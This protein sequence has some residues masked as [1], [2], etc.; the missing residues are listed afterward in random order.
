MMNY[1]IVGFFAIVF[2]MIFVDW[3]KKRERIIELERRIEKLE[4][5][6]WE[7]LGELERMDNELKNH[8]YGKEI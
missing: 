2:L 5:L 3:Y 6:F 8:I 7:F 4:N 1:A